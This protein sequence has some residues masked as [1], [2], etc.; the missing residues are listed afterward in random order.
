MPV[1]HRPVS[2]LSSAFAIIQVFLISQTC[3]S[4]QSPQKH[5]SVDLKVSQPQMLTLKNGQAVTIE[6]L[7][8]NE[9]RDTVRKGV[10]KVHAQFLINDQTFDL[11]SGPYSLPAKVGALRIDIP[12]TAGYNSNSTE[13][14]WRLT[15]GCDLRVRIW[16]EDGSL[17]PE[18]FIYPV[19]QQWFASGTQMANEPTFIDG[20]EDPSRTR[21]YYHSGL[22]IG[23]PEGLA[24]VV[25]AT[26]GT[27]VSLGH[28]IISNLEK[29]HPVAKR[30]DVIYLLDERGWYYRYSHLQ[31]FNPTLK[32][33]QK[34]SKGTS[35]GVL[36]KEGGSGGWAHLHFEIKARQPS[37]NYGTEEGYAFL[38]EAAVNRPNA[39]VVAVARP[40]RLVRVGETVELDASKSWSAVGGPLKIE[41]KLGSGQLASGPKVLVKYDKPGHYSEV[42][43]VTDANGNSSYDFAVTQV[44][45]PNQPGHL[46]PSIQAAFWPSLGVKPSTPVIFLTRTFRTTQGEEVWDFGDGT[47]EVRVKSDGN[48]K[49]LA[50]DGF[51]STIH[52]FSRSGDYIVRVSRTNDRGE[53]ATAHLHVRV[54]D[55]IK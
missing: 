8:F 54:E 31:Q 1:N 17:S 10:R 16:P 9:S 26:N 49:S 47:P 5:I 22:D 30:Y 32:L 4:A 29:D 19:R 28:E 18:Q 15:P 12:V 50:P 40:H 27:I 25:A 48:L 11:Q 44:L 36:G 43:M 23:G 3:V 2:L 24:E 20:G 38:W 51:A 41:W 39:R 14:H 13:D 6:L 34:V 35:L 33:G 53:K 21:I 52:R 46:P 55:P 7:K 37:G 42:A 45:D